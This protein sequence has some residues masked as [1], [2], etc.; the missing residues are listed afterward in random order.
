MKY[1]KVFE[2][3][4]KDINIGDIVKY[5][6]YNRYDGNNWDGYDKVVYIGEI[7]QIY[8]DKRYRFVVKY[9]FHYYKNVENYASDYGA[10]TIKQLNKS[11]INRMKKLSENEF[12]EI[13]IKYDSNKYN[14]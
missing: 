3:L 14:L 6:W 4:N 2:K 12:N 13:I 5:T 8:D 11:D 10:G 1:I 7:T 9:E